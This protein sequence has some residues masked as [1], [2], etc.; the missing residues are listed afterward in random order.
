MKRVLLSLLLLS[1][2]FLYGADIKPS[3]GMPVVEL[4]IIE[5]PVEE[6]NDIKTDNIVFN[7]YLTGVVTFEDVLHSMYFAQL[8]TN[9]NSYEFSRLCI[10]LNS[11]YFTKIGSDLSLI[12]LSV[13]SNPVNVSYNW[14]NF[15]DNKVAPMYEFYLIKQDLLGDTEYYPDPMTYYGYLWIELTN[16]QKEIGFTEEIRKEWIKLFKEMKPYYIH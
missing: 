16:K 12:N 13:L 8:G 2:S 6:I 1:A 7:Y 15:Y 4:K 9:L 5:L 11:Y 10:D 14:Y 3:I